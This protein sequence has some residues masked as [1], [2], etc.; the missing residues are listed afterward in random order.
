MSGWRVKARKHPV[1]VEPEPAKA[2]RHAKE[3][4]RRE[5]AGE[6]ARAR[7]WVTVWSRRPRQWP[8][9]GA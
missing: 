3:R 2:E 6:V 1:K 7:F 4:E 5:Q 9:A 8:H